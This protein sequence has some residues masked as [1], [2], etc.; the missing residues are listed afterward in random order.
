MDHPSESK[1]SKSLICLLCPARIYGNFRKAEPRRSPQRSAWRSNF[2]RPQRPAPGRLHR[3]L[4]A[5][6]FD[7][8]V[9][10]ARDARLR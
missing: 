10:Q 5:L 9:C 6:R 4:A 3:L 8:C 1:V 7:A 2:S